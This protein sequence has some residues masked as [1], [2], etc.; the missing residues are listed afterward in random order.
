[1]KLNKIS[2][3]NYCTLTRPGLTYSDLNLSIEAWT[4]P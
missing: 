3:L 4:I 2:F 1:M